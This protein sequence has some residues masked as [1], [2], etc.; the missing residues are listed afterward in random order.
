MSSSIGNIS[1]NAL[2]FLGGVAVGYYIKSL[3]DDDSF[4]Q[5]KYAAYSIFNSSSNDNKDYI[6]VEVEVIDDE[7]E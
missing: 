5:V 2:L 7:S 1:K 6:D 3:V 4:E